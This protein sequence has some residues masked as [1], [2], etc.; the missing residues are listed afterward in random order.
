MELSVAKD[1]GV[2]SPK[3]KMS[4]V[5]IPV[6]IPAPTLPKMSIARVVARDEAERF[7][8]LFP[9]NIAESIFLGRPTTLRAIAAFLLL[10]SAMVF[11]LILLTV[12]RAVSADEK[13]AERANKT[14]NTNNLINRCVS[15]LII[16]L[17]IN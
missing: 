16:S 15:N 6:A 7:T 4:N 13:K 2:I 12:V 10:S 17:I 11:S 9:I 8:M 14:N 1:F 3:I 5:R